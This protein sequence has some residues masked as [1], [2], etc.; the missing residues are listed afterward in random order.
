MFPLYDENFRES[1]FPLV[2]VFIIIICV[3]VFW[4]TTFN[5]PQTYTL[6]TGNNPRVLLKDPAVREYIHELEVQGINPLS[7][8]GISILANAKLVSLLGVVP[9][10]IL[11]GKGFMTLLTSLFLHGGFLHLLG[12]MWFLWIF[13]DNVENIFGKFKY[14]LFYLTA[15]AVAALAHVFLVPASD[16]YIPV[17]GASGGI[18][19]VLGSY[20]VMLPRHRIATFFTLGFFF[21]IIRVPAFFFLGIWFLYQFLLFNTPSNVAYTAHIAGFVFGITIGLLVKI[22]GRARI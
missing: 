9:A 1:K 20:A 17:I 21:R 4:M 6:L 22:S 12:N 18:A 3:I 10:Q 19:A 11:N 5:A 8:E 16:I 15:G 7:S 14:L 2:T 13:G